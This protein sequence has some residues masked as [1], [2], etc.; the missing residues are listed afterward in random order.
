MKIIFYEYLPL[1]NALNA[2]NFCSYIHLSHSKVH[3]S[4]S[5]SNRVVRSSRN[6]MCLHISIIQDFIGKHE[7]LGHLRLF[8]GE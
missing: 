5:R 7:T 6:A 8:L 1:V 4:G 3:V 2:L